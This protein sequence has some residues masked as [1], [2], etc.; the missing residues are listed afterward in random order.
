[1][2]RNAKQ[3]EIGSAVST[4]KGKSAINALYA[5]VTEASHSGVCNNVSNCS[6]SSDYFYGGATQMISCNGQ[7]Y[8]ITY[9]SSNINTA[10]QFCAQYNNASGAWINGTMP[11]GCST[12][13]PSG[14][15][16]QINYG[17]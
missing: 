9:N 7:N 13:Y 1:M 17:C 8:F 2:P 15:N 16:C 6:G 14:R 10:S 3:T 5:P 12:F 11:C 4:H